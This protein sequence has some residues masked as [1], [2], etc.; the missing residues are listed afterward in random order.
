MTL[1][2]HKRIRTPG[3]RPLALEQ[4]FMF[5][6]AAATAG[7]EPSVPDSLPD[8]GAATQ[9]SEH[10]PASQ[11]DTSQNHE[12]PTTDYSAQQ[13]AT[14]DRALNEGRLDVVFI[15]D[16]VSDYQSLVD[17]MKAGIEIV[18]LDSRGDGL[19][20]MAKYLSGRSEID[21]IHLISHGAEG[22]LNL[23]ALT[24]DTIALQNRTDDLAT[25]GAALTI[26]GD[27]LLYGCAVASGEGNAF[28]SAMATATGADVAASDNA[29]G[30]EVL[31]G[32]WQLETA[33][34]GIEAATP[35]TSPAL[36]AYANILASATLTGGN[37][38]PVLSAGADS[39]IADTTNTLNSGDQID[40]LAGSDTLEIS[41]AQTVTFN[42]TTL[43]NVEVITIS[44]GIQDI[45]SHDATV[46]AGQTLA[47][48]ASASS[49][50][51][52][53]NGGAET[54]GTFSITGG[55]GHD[56]ILG[57]A[58]NDTLYG[59]AGNDT[60][61]GGA[62]DDLLFG[63]DG[64]DTLYG[65][66]GNDTLS[67][68][69][70]NDFL[71]GLEND[72]LIYGG[73]GND[74]ISGGD[75]N[76]SMW[77]GIGNDTIIGGNGAD[78][79]YGED[80]ND[81]IWGQ[82]DNDLIYGGDGNDTISGDAGN[83]T[84][85]GGAGNDILRGLNDNDL[86]YG[87]AGNDTLSGGAGS[88]TLFGG[89]DND[90]FTG[91]AAHLDGDTIGDFTT[92]DNIL[93]LGADLSAL[94]NTAASG[95][96]D[97]GGGQT[98]TLTGITAASGKFVAVFSGGNTTITLVPNAPPVITSDGGGVNAAV[99]AA[100]NQTAVTTV[101]AT[102]GDGDTPTFSISGGADQAK[103]SIDPN[104][105]V[106]S[107]ISAPDFE[108][109]SDSD[110]NNSYVVQVTADDGVGG[111]DIQ[112]I[113]VTVTNVNEAP[114][115]TSNG[116]GVN[117]A[118]N[119]AENQSA[120]TTVTAS[121]VDGDTP[122]FSISGG[123]DQ[124]KFSIDPNTGVL[125]FISAPDFENPSDSDGN[126]S[127]VVQVTA[128]DGVGGM[129]IQTITVTVT[130]VNEAPVITSNGGGVNAAVNAAENQSA[131][132]TVTASDVDGDTPT[133]SISGGADQAKFS[134]DPNTGVLSFISAP[135]FENPSDSD[136][137]N[138]YVVQVTADDGVGGMD[139]QTITVTV[140]N[141]NEAPV[142]T[143]NGGG[144]N[145]AVNAAENQ[146]AVTTVTASDVDGDT[147]TFSISG[148]ADQAKFS[149]DPNTGVLSFISAPDFE[150][151][152][153][154]DGNNSYVV[155]VTADDGVGGMDIQTIT[156][157]VTNVN[158]A[159]VITSNG[160]GVNAAVNAAEN[161]S[162][163]TTVT[164]SDVDGD[165]PTF[166]ISGGADQAKFSIDPNT[167]V[168][169]FISAPDFENPS[170]SDG[171]NSYVVQVTADDGVG[172]MDIQTITVTVTNVNEAPVITSNGGGVNAAV[173]AAENQSAVTTVTASDVD[174]DTPTFS[175]SG[176][177]DQAKFSIDPNT[178]VL[179]FISAPD[180]ESPSDSDGN[181]SYVV[182]V[183]ADDGVGGMDIQTIT[184]TVTNV[185]EAPVITS[186]G[187]GVNAAVNAAENQSAV[188]TVTASDGD[189]DT[190][191]FSISGGADQAKFSIDPNTGVLTFISAPDF[192]NP[193]DS[194]GNN[195]YVVQVTAA[196]GNGGSDIQTITVTVTNV[197]EAPVIT[198]NGGGVNAAVNAAENQ[199]AV[200]T[201]TASDGDSD[202]PTFS[203]SGGAD[204]AK[205]SID[206][207][208]GVLT[209][210]SAPDFENPTDS[211]GNNSY[212]VQVTAADGNGGSDIQTI[213]VTVT[214]VNE[215][216]VITSNGGGVNAAVNAAENQ[217]AVTT[218]TASDGDS[219]TPTFSI[220][221]GADQAKFSIDPNTGVLTFISAPDFEN[222]SDSD[223]NN[224]YV[225]QVTADDGNG[226]TA[227]QTITVTVT[228]L[229]DTAANQAP[230]LPPAPTPAAPPSVGS[231]PSTTPTLE[232]PPA[233]ANQPFLHNR[234][235]GTSGLVAPPVDASI[236][237]AVFSI[238]SSAALD[239]G[240]GDSS[241][242][243]LRMLP[244]FGSTRI[245]Q[246][247]EI[248]LALP[249]E[250]F[251]ATGEF[252][253]LELE[254]LQ[255]DG[256]GLP[257][258]LTF[259]PR[260]GLFS[261]KAPA[262]FTGKVSV[263]VIARD[264]QGN[265]RVIQL[266]LDIVSGE[267]IDNGDA[268]EATAAERN[269]ALA[270]SGRAG[271]SEQLRHA[272]NR[273]ELAPRLAAL[274]QSVQAARNHT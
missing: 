145:A 26:D 259:D 27:L 239:L 208:T 227:V 191:T 152:S 109:P 139:I 229:G 165:T 132:T 267:V 135:D 106:L 33:T 153:D 207:N 55:A 181:N 253:I 97:L 92:A 84:L 73:A 1:A 242:P 260:T 144:V 179:S 63:D 45:T 211:D 67:G 265:E 262:D 77:G 62:G 216:P 21:A 98:L 150:N 180:F 11:K 121:D 162:A 90:T 184:V 110:G 29:T 215:A 171:N 177:A 47:V 30:S 168:L 138:S 205:F 101:T 270:P 119:A 79:I 54:D 83:D 48:D 202:T 149:I 269:A 32:D 225:V 74:G 193:T 237:D 134:I 233:P 81:W 38:T 25:L 80:G 249:L 124:A 69:D 203:I 155:Q 43:T 235:L 266:E 37:D 53:W 250:L 35:I 24:L 192:E 274:T 22:R 87:D 258:W 61:S 175:I 199:S 232:A 42:A 49:A 214:N 94:N 34:G 95:T 217:S 123:A 228:D 188:T 2:S 243:A 223:S 18:L 195:S 60:L 172:G 89:A 210:I 160:G 226:G 151:P 58:G 268:P 102:D 68:G 244:D 93:V 182:Q 52:T 140:T 147:P 117:A 224:S 44:A 246:G 156:V 218:V 5:D 198:S 238:P 178:G 86:I 76:D 194:D 120:V 125:S 129:D 91:T 231:G 13:L 107:F 10:A 154:S 241:E 9:H 200:T 64:N 17:G 131:V 105:G 141:V 220:S 100:E 127:Y 15:E 82:N 206:P 39:I 197:N 31:R 71:Y 78:L 247:S 6:G 137:N 28:V 167:G 272:S 46:A 104:T 234:A 112:T 16:N 183:T 273:S 255:G 256:Q 257:D 157:T 56:S 65:G 213:T 4:R 190:P 219:D 245:V 75:G 176:G 196:D 161:Q 189:G 204:Q 185:N 72:D 222:P 40:G 108:N 164:A 201:V 173:N 143:S 70:G 212:V 41:A 158:E 85:Y 240:L 23:G 51:L 115:I 14:A 209:F 12:K 166:S 96:I 122:T 142:I 66:L 20:Q 159:P 103:F 146:S 113:T 148:G 186:N 116:G 50:K 88:D 36:A 57:G 118:V 8:A 236:F 251:S 261:G 169:S 59:G 252:I 7:L 230:I 263:K 174:G 163:V 3:I 133:F 271:L 19:Q 128:D 114:V 126:N 136:G 248:S 170:D 130:N 187:G 99:N 264:S 254:A 221:G 111:M